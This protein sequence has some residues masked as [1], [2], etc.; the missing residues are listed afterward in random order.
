MLTFWD[1]LGTKKE[2]RTRIKKPDE[3]REQVKS[4]LQKDNQGLIL[5]VRS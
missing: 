4:L 5:M 2:K 1:R 3:V